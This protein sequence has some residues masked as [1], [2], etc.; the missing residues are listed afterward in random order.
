MPSL[1]WTVGLL[2]AA[3]ASPGASGCGRSSAGLTPEQDA[4]AV[5]LRTTMAHPNYS[6]PSEEVLRKTLEPLAYEVTQHGGTEPPFNNRFWNNHEEG[7]YVDVVSGEPLFSS[8]DKFDSGTGWPSFT[9]PL[10]KDAVVEHVDTS[11][12]MKRTEVRSK[13]ANSHLGHVFDDGPKPEGLRYCINSAALRFV[14]KAELVQQGYAEF[15]S[16]FDEPKLDGGDALPVANSCTAP[17]QGN[18]A[19][20]KTTMEQ[21]YLAGGCFWGMQEILRQIPG[22]LQTEVGYMGGTT[23]NPDYEDVH[24]GTTGHAETVRIV[25]DPERLKYSELL[26]GWFFRM[27][28]PTTK[29]QQGNDRGSQYR[30]AIFA[31]SDEQTRVAKEVIAR[32]QQSGRWRNPIV[33]EV[34]PAGAFYPA[35]TYHQ[36]Y[37]QKHPGGYTCHYL[38]P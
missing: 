1:S 26:E 2:A 28:D 6:K 16:R 18:R 33:T 7:I 10:V 25:F 23:S 11:F 32:V 12:G 9:T 14:P 4:A 37:L 5:R 34:R 30:S 24:T 19:G 29:D 17:D 27:H 13:A 38:R 36:D 35:E 31:T 20:C 3:L 22:V 21:A 15:A 8:R